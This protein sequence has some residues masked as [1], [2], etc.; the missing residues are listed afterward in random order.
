MKKGFEYYIDKE[1]IREYRKWS[2]KEKLRWLSE[3]NYLRK[4]YP[5]KTI[6]IQE[7]FR[8]GEI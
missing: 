3:W 6:E 4:Y 5:K 7:K 1:K 2:V 8:R